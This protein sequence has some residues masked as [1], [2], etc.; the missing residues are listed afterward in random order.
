MAL[1]A[2]TDHALPEAETRNREGGDCADKTYL[3]RCP[4]EWPPLTTAGPETW[5]S[6]ICEE[7]VGGL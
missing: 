4:F 2:R 6:L 5:F 3:L 1:P 7:K